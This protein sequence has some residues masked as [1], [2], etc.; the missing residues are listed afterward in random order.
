MPV[1]S[2]QQ[3]QIDTKVSL[4]VS[5]L[6]AERLPTRALFAISPVMSRVES[7]CVGV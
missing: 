5:K 2:L 6:T 1:G 3:E 4:N 7:N